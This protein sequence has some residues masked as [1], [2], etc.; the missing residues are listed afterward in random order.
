MPGAK[1]SSAKAVIGPTPV[2]VRRCVAVFAFSASR[3][4]FW[5]FASMR[6]FSSPNLLQQIHACLAHPQG[7]RSLTGNRRGTTDL[8]CICQTNMAELVEKGSQGVHAFVWLMHEALL[9]PQQ[10][11]ALAAPRSR[12]RQSHLWLS[13]G[14]DDRLRVGSVIFPP[15]YESA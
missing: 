9:G 14:N 7:Q 10:R 5:V 15:L 1:A 6:S 4:A 8:S 12:E 13:R 2:M 3:C 11:R